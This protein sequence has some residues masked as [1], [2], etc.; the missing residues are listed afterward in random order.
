MAT[1]VMVHGA[2]HG[3]WCFDLLRPAL[4]AAGHTLIAPDLPGMG[5]TDEELASA[6]LAG[7]ADYVADI[8]RTAQQPVILCGHS[9]GGI[10]ISE[11]A[12]RLPD[13]VSSLV[14]ICAMLLPSG[15]ARTDLKA[16][17]GPNALM[18]SMLKRHP[19]GHATVVDPT[20][21]PTL[22][23]HLSPPDLAAA[24]AARTVAEPNAPRQTPLTLT[25]ARYGGVPRHYI[26]C[27]EDRT[28]LIGEQRH[29][30]RLQ[31]C[32]SVTTLETD[33]SPFLSAPEALAAALIALA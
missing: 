18:D 16:I 26:E 7:W 17:F 30:Q 28:I 2:W 31:P 6:T 5:G 20:L 25:A 12:E 9:R 27:S 3:G 4:E 23:A 11:V 21:A 14:Y 22:F 13:Q 10:V 19:S 15:M 32:V 1:F 24:A 29:M 8:V 33:H